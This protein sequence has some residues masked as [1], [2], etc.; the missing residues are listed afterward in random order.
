M[1]DKEEDKE[2]LMTYSKDNNIDNGN[3]YWENIQVRQQH[4]IANMEQWRNVNVL[5]VDDD[6]NN[7]N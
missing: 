1:Y 7:T 3:D 2:W 6:N 5:F 4:K